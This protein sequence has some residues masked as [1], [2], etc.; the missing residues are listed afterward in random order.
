MKGKMETTVVNRLELILFVSNVYSTEN[1]YINTEVAT[2]IV[3]TVCELLDVSLANSLHIHE[4]E[5]L[6]FFAIIA[7]LA[8][9]IT[10]GKIEVDIREKKNKFYYSH[11]EYIPE[12]MKERIKR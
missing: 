11:C 7:D 12:R 4:D 2:A 1:C 9:K 3:E 10:S 8:H 5:V 6:E